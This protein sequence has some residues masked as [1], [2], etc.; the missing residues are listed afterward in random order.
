MSQIAFQEHVQKRTVEEGLER[1]RTTGSILPE[2]PGV[3][4][5]STFQKRRKTKAR[6]ESKVRPTIL[7][8]RKKKHEYT[9]YMLQ[10]DVGGSFKK[11][12]RTTAG[13]RIRERGFKAKRPKRKEN[14]TPQG[15][16]DRVEWSET[17]ED[18]EEEDW[19]GVVFVDEH[20]MTVPSAKTA[21]RQQHA[22][23]RFYWGEDGTVK[24]DNPYDN[25]LVAPKGGKNVMGGTPVRAIFAILDDEFIVVEDTVSFV[26]R[27]K[28]IPKNKPKKSKNGKPLGRPPKILKT[29]KQ[30]KKRRYDAAAHA[31]F[32]RDMHKAAV[33][34]L[35]DAAKNGLQVVHVYQDGLR[36]HRTPHCRAVMNEL[37]MVDHKPPKC[38]YS[39]DTNCIEE[40]FAIVDDRHHKE[41]M[42]KRC[43]NTEE[44]MKRTKEIT[45]GMGASG[46]GTVRKTVDK[47]PEHVKDILAN[48]GG[49][50]RW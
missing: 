30:I 3:K 36:L 20:G 13:K 44:W 22:R 33:A 26:K 18:W 10:Q 31:V 14:Y 38:G 21:S 35:G 25:G 46:D 42:K 5:G 45:T 34:K 8:N 6:C 1:F 23:K 15:R 7:K 47:M 11:V 39:P 16:R 19:R 50:T 27:S 41:Q 48:K 43:P 28:P 40:L 37:E 24:K 32:L 49:P 17:Y 2:V 4:E 29:Q 9:T 12:H